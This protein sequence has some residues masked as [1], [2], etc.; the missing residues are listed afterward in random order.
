MAQIAIKKRQS[1]TTGHAAWKDSCDDLTIKALIDEL[2]VPHLVEEFL[3]LYVPSP[4]ENLQEKDLSAHPQTE[5]NST[6]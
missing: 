5:L 3:R 6:P 1:L 2:I 4:A